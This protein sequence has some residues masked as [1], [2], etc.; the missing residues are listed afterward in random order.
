MEQVLPGAD[1]DDWESDP[2]LDSNDLKEAGR[3]AD[4]MA[5]LQGLLAQDLRCLDAHA[6]LRNAAFDRDPELAFRHYCVGAGI[7]DQALGP[8]FTGALPRGLID[9]RPYLRCLHGVGLCHWRLG[10]RKEAA[11]VFTRMLWL[12]P[13]DNQGA[14]F[15]LDHVE[16]GLDWQPDDE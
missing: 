14:R 6:H 2:I 1:P 7:G 13:S 3:Y 9:N 8:G 10:R 16:Q 12:N 11:E 4:A 15:N 5:L